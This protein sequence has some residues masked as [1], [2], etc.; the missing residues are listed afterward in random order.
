MRKINLINAC[1]LFVFCF[2][3][4]ITLT[5]Q[6]S[7]AIEDEINQI[8]AQLTLE[9]KVAMCHAQSKFS[10]KGV[11]RLGIPELWMSDGPHGVR[12]EVNW[13][14]WGYSMWTN[15]SITAFPA[16]TAL[17]STFSKGLSYEYGKAIGEEARYRNKDVLLG[18]GVNIYRTPL[19]GRNFE[20]MGEDPYL[21]SELVVPYIKGVQENGVAACVK[22]FVANNQELWRDHIN[23]EV[24][25]R[26]LNEIYFPAFKA[27]VEEGNV[28]SVMSAYNQLRGQYC[29][30]NEFL[31]NEVLKK[32]W[33]FDGVLI[34]DWG[35]A[36]DSKQAALYGLDIEMG[37]GTNGLTYSEVNHY[38]NY[39]MAG[40]MKELVRKGEVPEEVVDEKVRRILRL[41]YRT[42]LDKTRPFGSVN[43]KEHQ[44]V[45]RRVAA[46]G[47]VLLKNE[48]KLLPL[49]IN[50]KQ[51]IAII[52]ENAT[53]MMTKGGGSS[54]L[55]PK[56]EI[57]PLEGLKNRLPDHEITYAMGYSSGRA[58]YGMVLPPVFDQEE[59][60]KEALETVKDAD[61]VIFYGGLNKNHEQDCEGGDRLSYQLPFGQEDLINDLAKVNKNI[62]VV[63]ISGNAVEMQWEKNA[64]AVLQGWYL[65]S[66]GGNALA[67]VIVGDV[68]PSG[69]LPFTFP[70]K[71]EDNS[72]HHF[73]KMSYPGDSINQE[74]KDD[75]LVGYRWHDTKKIK[76]KYAFG[77]GLSYTDFLISNVTLNKKTFN[78]QETIIASCD[79]KN[80]GELEGKEVVQFY[81]E[82]VKS[83]VMRAKKELKAFSKVELK[84]GDTQ[85]VK[86]EV[87]VLSLR[88]YDEEMKDWVLEPGDYLLHVGNS[89]DNIRKSIKFSIVEQIE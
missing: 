57:S 44:M 62:V 29:S 6:E 3:G 37:T 12:A 21:A 47:I 78:R 72:A 53:R 35:A 40:P 4:H 52:G 42:T 30:H 45:A 73:G 43:S 18:P 8:I 66:E 71:L 39:Y 14:D 89:S 7:D 16:L 46:E 58:Q 79:V 60:K 34:T 56:Y 38:E 80:I 19:N 70:K 64:R 67:D 26:A 76:P 13:D 24:S 49:D 17:A 69:K 59:L 5:A 32:K 86:G 65:G 54:E 2:S 50:K 84:K 88:Y 82:K 1:L 15:D 68:N 63:L 22:H 10:S 9:E 41:M 61:V 25:D 85:E 20:Y 75:I 28:W 87:D 36:H 27:A 81:V 74:Y 48:E 51:K 33:N 83:K 11:P 55:K 77:Y 31:V 23:V